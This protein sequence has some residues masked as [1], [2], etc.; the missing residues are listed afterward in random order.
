MSRPNTGK[1]QEESQVA[2]N[3]ARSA[4]DQQKMDT[5]AGAETTAIQGL[6]ATPGLGPD[7]LAKAKARN[8][9]VMGATFGGAE[10][11]LQRNAAAT[12]HYADVGL[13]PSVTKLAEDKA[14][15]ENQSNMDYGLQDAE[16]A[17]ATRRAIPGMY[18][19]VAA[20]YGAQ[21]TALSGQNASMIGGRMST[22]SAPTFGQQMLLAG[23][24][25]AGTAAA[26][27]L[28]KGGCWIAEAIYGVTDPR[29]LLIRYWLNSEFVKHAFGRMVMALY[30]RHGRRVARMVKRS[31]A[32][33]LLFRP[34]FELALR[35]ARTCALDQSGT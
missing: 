3:T 25:S 32:L 31:L 4:A 13:A 17:L 24:N 11:A 27:Y 5:A 2:T 34:L 16:Q 10:D 20:P 29:T 8:A 1:K 9:D 28:G 30:L 35:K 12:G 7:F 23:M 15:M 14:Q 19:G 33:R 26:G 6:E 22:D 18:S 21:G